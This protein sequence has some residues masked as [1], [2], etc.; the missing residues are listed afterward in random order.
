MGPK[1]F[2]ASSYWAVGVDG[3]DHKVLVQ[4]GDLSGGQVRIALSPAAARDF[5]LRERGL[6]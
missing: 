2:R 5:A 4:L 3:P 6:S 1:L